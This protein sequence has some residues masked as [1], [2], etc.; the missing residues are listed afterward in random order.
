MM[1]FI[2]VRISWL[3]LARNSDF[4]RVAASARSMAPCMALLRMPRMRMKISMSKVLPNCSACMVQKLAG[5][6]CR[7]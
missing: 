4:M 2:G 5:D 1:A 3:M 7:R 6:A